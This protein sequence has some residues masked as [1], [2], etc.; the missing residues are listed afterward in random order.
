MYTIEK[1]EARTVEAMPAAEGLQVGIITDY[2]VLETG[3]GELFYQLWNCEN[4]AML[5]VS[6]IFGDKVI[7]KSGIT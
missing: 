3:G 2:K 5:K 7:L 4:G 6:E 1:G